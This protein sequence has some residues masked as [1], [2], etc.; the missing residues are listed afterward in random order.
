MDPITAAIVAALS[1]GAISG[2]TETSKTAISDA[3]QA[4]KDLLARKWGVASKVVEAVTLLE[5]KPDSTG[6][7]N[8]LQE[9]IA[10]ASVEHDTEALA[11]AQ[12][13]QTLVQ[14]QQAGLGKFTIQN[15]AAVQGQSVG[16]HNTITQHFGKLPEGNSRKSRKRR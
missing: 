1:A 10:A 2:L 4:L 11:L 16:D 6:R 15:N 5:A 13:L 7:Q 3:Y 8:I 9:E 14:P 12:Q